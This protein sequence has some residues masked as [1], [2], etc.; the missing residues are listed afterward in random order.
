VRAL[1]RRQLPRLTGAT[2]IDSLVERGTYR[3][4]IAAQTAGTLNVRH[5]SRPG[6]ARRGGDLIAS[7]TTRFDVA[8]HHPVM[9]R[10]TRAGARLVSG[11]GTV[12]LR[13]TAIFKPAVGGAIAISRSIQIQP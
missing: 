2:A 3:T 10:L 4:T 6:A 1:L 8:G 13:V 7:G 5:S 11:K 9:L 12:S